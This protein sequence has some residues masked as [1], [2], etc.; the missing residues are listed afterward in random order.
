MN[1]R[2][3]FFA[4]AT[5][6][7]LGLFAAPIR[8]NAEEPPIQPAVLVD[9]DGDGLFDNDEPTYGTDPDLYDTDGDGFGDN[10]EVITGSDPLDPAIVPANGEPGVDTDGDLL[11]DEQEADLG[12]NPT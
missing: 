2:R 9:T 12:T 1:A 5:L 8:A 11:T 10:Q 3:F 6:L 4:I 7:L